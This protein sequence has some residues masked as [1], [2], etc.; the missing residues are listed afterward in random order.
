MG[1]IST[2]F[3]AP[4]SRAPK[5][6]LKASSAME[7]AATGQRNL[8]ASSRFRRTRLRVKNKAKPSR[9]QRVCLYR[10]LGAL[11][12]VTVRQSVVRKKAKVSISN[13]RRRKIR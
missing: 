1:P 8:L 9:M 10:E 13:P 6:T 7:K 4:K 12:A 2:Q 5:S 3:R 11:S